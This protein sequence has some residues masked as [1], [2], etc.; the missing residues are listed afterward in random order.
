MT[1]FGATCVLVGGLFV[2]AC[3]AFVLVC[4][5]AGADA[6]RSTAAAGLLAATGSLLVVQGLRLRRRTTS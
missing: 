4:M 2:L 3:A 6:P 5:F 1:P